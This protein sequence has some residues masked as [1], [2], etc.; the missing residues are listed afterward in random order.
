MS[1]TR[2]RPA[3]QAQWKQHGLHDGR[4]R[5]L[6]DRQQL[7][8]FHV[9]LGAGVFGHAPCG[10]VVLLHAGPFCERHAAADLIARLAGFLKW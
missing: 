5:Y 3:T 8:C 2:F 1:G 10:E 6:Y 4:P 9:R 7:N